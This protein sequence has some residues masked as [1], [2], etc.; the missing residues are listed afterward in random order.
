MSVP[1]L[2]RLLDRHADAAAGFSGVVAVEAVGG[3]GAFDRRTGGLADRAHGIEMT[4]GHRIGVAS[5]PKTLTALAVLSCLDDGLLDLHQPIRPLLGD[6]LP[7]V[8]DRVT[9]DMLLRHRSGIGDYLDE[10][11]DD[12]DPLAYTMRLPLHT[13]DGADGYAR[14]IDGHPQQFEP[15]SGFAYCNSGYVLLAILVERVT[16]GTFDAAVERR[17]CRPAGLRDT[18]FE[19]MDSLPGTCAVGYAEAVGLRT[20]VLHL[21]VIGFGDGGVFTSV[22]DVH[23]LWR[24]MIDGPLTGSF[25]RMRTG[26]PDD[27]RYGMGLWLD[28]DTGAVWME[29]MDVGAS[30]R[31][32]WSPASSRI[33]TVMSNTTRGAWPVDRALRDEVFRATS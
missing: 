7:L 14:A 10:N 6:D 29:G 5:G 21:P 15:D 12:H 31:S 4:V 16:G 23:R 19:R 17:V 22:A 11:V 28:D 25:V 24:S 3:H 33:V 26:H 18:G 32:T 13:L 9:V 2:D 1:A 8:D 30:F 20:N 27:G